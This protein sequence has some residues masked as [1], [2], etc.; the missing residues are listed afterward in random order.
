MHVFHSTFEH[1]HTHKAQIIV[2]PLKLSLNYLLLSERNELHQ[3]ATLSLS[4][5]TNS[6]EFKHEQVELALPSQ[7]EM[8]HAHTS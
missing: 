5:S 8:S 1:T 6:F 3:G 4:D 7:V 2:V